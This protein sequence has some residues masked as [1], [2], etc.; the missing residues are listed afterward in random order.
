LGRSQPRVTNPLRFNH[1][2]TKLFPLP[3]FTTTNCALKKKK[4]QREVQQ[5]KSTITIRKNALMSS[6]VDQIRPWKELVSLNINQLEDSRRRRKRKASRRRRKG[7]EACIFKLIMSKNF[8]KLMTDTK[9][10]IQNTQRISR[11][12]KYLKYHI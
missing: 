2:V 1:Q 12:V 9:P 6:T 8:T 4:N 7:T 11:K 5:I 3:H 10:Q